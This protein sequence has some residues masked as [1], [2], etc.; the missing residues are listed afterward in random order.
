MKF[1]KSPQTD[2]NNLIE[3]TFREQLA[4]REFPSNMSWANKTQSQFGKSFFSTMSFSKGQPSAMEKSF[5]NNKSEVSKNTVSTKKR[6]HVKQVNALLGST[7]NT[8]FSKL[9]TNH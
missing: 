6:L 8:F 5:Y 4:S 2:P 1:A 3:A 9:K 7:G